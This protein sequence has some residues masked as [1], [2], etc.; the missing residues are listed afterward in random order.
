[1]TDCKADNDCPDCRAE[2]S[3]REMQAAGMP[4][5]DVLITMVN[6]L[7][8]NLGEVAPNDILRDLEAILVVYY[9]IEPT[10]IKRKCV[11][12]VVE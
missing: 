12:V 9:G 5:V 1:M 3:I 8:E 4:L 2:K 7:N 6:G 11:N 10:D